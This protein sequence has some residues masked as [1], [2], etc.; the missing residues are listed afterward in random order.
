MN[1]AAGASCSTLRRSVNL[2]SSAVNCSPL[3]NWTSSRRSKVYVVPSSLTVQSVARSETNWKS[4]FI[5]MRPLK[6]LTNS[7]T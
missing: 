1:E 2:T 7:I 3:W 5:L 6:T 4:L